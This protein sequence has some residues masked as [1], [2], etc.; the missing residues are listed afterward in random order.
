MDPE[1]EDQKQGFGPAG[2]DYVRAFNAPPAE[3]AA[4]LNTLLRRD[5]YTG[6]EPPD[7]PIMLARAAQIA[8]VGADSLRHAAQRGALQAARP[9]HDWITTRRQLHRYLA[10]RRRGVVKPLPAGYQTPDGEEPIDG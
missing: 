4:M 3:Q 10:G 6:L 2:D 8:G 9:G 1:K 7:A 5:P